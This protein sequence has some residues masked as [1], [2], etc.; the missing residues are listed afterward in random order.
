[1][2]TNNKRCVFCN[3]ATIPYRT[4]MDSVESGL[5]CN[6]ISRDEYIE[7]EEGKAKIIFPKSNTVFYNNVQVFNR[8][9]SIS[10]IK[11]FTQ[12]YQQSRKIPATEKDHEALKYVAAIKDDGDN[13]CT[14]MDVNMEENIEKYEGTSKYIADNNND[15]DDDGDDDKN[16]DGDKNQGGDNKHNKETDSQFKINI[17]EALSATG[18]RAIRYALEIPLVNKI[19]AN[20][21]SKKAVTNIKRNIN[22]N[23]VQNIVK[24]SNADASMLLY[25]HRFPLSKR[26]QVVDLDPYG[27]PCQF[28]DGALQAID[29]G[30]LLCVTCTDMGALC[31]NHGEAAYAKYGG[32]PFRAKYCHEMAIRIVLACLDTH[33]GRYKRY[34]QPLVSLSADFYIRLFVRVFTSASEVKRSASKK[35]YVFHCN[36]CET[37]TLQPVGF[38]VEDGSSRKYKA[39][40]G[41]VVGQRCEECGYTFKIGGPI[42][43][44][45]MHDLPFINGLLTTIQGMYAYVST[46]GG[47]REI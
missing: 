31:G 21:L 4:N 37:F 30:G 46:Y 18:L 5:Q 27:S 16:Q 41:P 3:L 12:L 11:Y 35:S 26:F 38:S 28:L 20:D 39:G 32:L 44:Q 15:G 42:W 13:T 43:S 36:G 25:Q 40:V 19:I 29:D 10:V 34:I 17:L 33:A 24:S 8:D 2:Y 47:G 6:D 1:M 9:L 22:H 7:I 23:G 45:P 14:N